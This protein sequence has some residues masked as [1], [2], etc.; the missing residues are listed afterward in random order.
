M[1]IHFLTKITHKRTNSQTNSQLVP[2]TSAA[3]SPA[4]S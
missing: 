4:K 2:S 1:H 3:G